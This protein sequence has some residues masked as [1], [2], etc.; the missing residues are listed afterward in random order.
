MALA[1]QAIEMAAQEA[2]LDA[3][4]RRVLRVMRVDDGRLSRHRRRDH[5]TRSP[6]S[7]PPRTRYV[8][9][10]LPAGSRIGDQPH[11]LPAARPGGASARPRPR[12]GQQRV[13]R[14]GARGLGGSAGV[15]DRGGIGAC[16][17][18]GEWHRRAW[19]LV[20]A[21]WW[22]AVADACIRHR[23]GERGRRERGRGE[24][25]REPGPRQGVR[26][27]PGVGPRRDGTRQRSGLRRQDRRPSGFRHALGG[28]YG[29][30]G[31][32]QRRPGNG[33]SRGDQPG[34]GREPW[35][36]RGGRARR[37]TD[38]QGD[39]ALAG[40]GRRPP[41]R[42]AGTR[43]NGLARRTVAGP[44]R[45][46]PRAAWPGAAGPA[47]L[48]PDRDRGDAGRG[49]PCR[50]APLRGGGCRLDGGWDPDISPGTR[51]G[52]SHASAGGG[53]APVRPCSSGSRS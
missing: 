34:R 25:G 38:S 46:R 52:G 41:E 32:D 42:R 53:T 19:R 15:P 21:G 6:A 14:P 13:R 5:T 24:R 8:T 20:V 11:Q 50:H 39:P 9:L 22:C 51:G 17:R 2:P 10:V 40:V 36:S 44:A 31:R 29:L 1:F 48:G 43:G 37:P 3:A 47:S 26:R 49:D 18:S 16:P 33:A 23:H 35:R 27:R 28:K 12:R 45:P 30:G 4:L 7:V